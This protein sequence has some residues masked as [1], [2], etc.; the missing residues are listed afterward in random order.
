[1]YAAAVVMTV[2][3]GILLC[4]A[5]KE[6]A[7]EGK[8]GLQK[9]IYQIAVFL[10]RRAEARGIM[11]GADRQVRKDLER[12]RP[13]ENI[14][15]IC[16]VYYVEK[17]VKFLL[18]SLAGTLLGVLISCQAGRERRLENQGEISRNHYLEAGMEIVLKETAS[19]ERFHILVEEK[20]LTEE[21]A[22]EQYQRFLVELHNYLCGTASDMT[23][24]SQDIKLPE[25]L[26]GYPF[27][28]EW[29]SERP[30]LMS[31]AGEIG[32]I[33]E[34]ET[35]LLRA[36]ITYKEQEWQEEFAITVVPPLRSEQEE[37]HRQLE[38]LLTQSQAASME[39]AVWQLPAEWNGESLTW[40]QIVPDRG[41][42]VWLGGLGTAAAV[43]FLQD[44]DLHSDLEK[45]RMQ[46][47][48]QYPDVVQKLILYLGA[49]MTI[50][51]VFFKIAGDYKQ[52]RKNGGRMQPVM[53][54][55]LYSCRELQAGAAEGAAYEHF[56]RR[57]GV[58]EYIRLCTLLQQNLKKGNSTLL[59]RLREEADRA[60]LEK[61]QNSR[62][63]G[64]EAVTKLLL[65]MVMMLL[66]VM[67]MIMIPAFSTTTF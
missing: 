2:L 17:T 46:I 57:T 59:S 14:Q 27:V 63:K 19:G 3:F 29:Q 45:R 65:P 49:G 48:Q 13:G 36:V 30:E 8:T 7:P 11:S 67:V 18:I 55:V 28:I 47:K 32:D 16:H 20:R 66:V 34:K 38:M 60:S 4:L 44:R 52:E 23:E 25:S 53:E 58:Q 24:V 22:E 37:R 10:C 15:Q 43:F 62:R 12:L 64:E 56:G 50:R 1:M 42:L 6:S 40:Q 41:I 33:Q 39:E 61:L 54:E 21:E 26:E 35:F 9:P 5:G 31:N 51:G